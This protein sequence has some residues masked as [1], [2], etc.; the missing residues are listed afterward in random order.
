MQVLETNLKVNKETAGSTYMETAP[1]NQRGPEMFQRLLGQ[2]LLNKRLHIA[3]CCSLLLPLR[4]KVYD[5]FC[6]V[7]LVLCG[8]SSLWGY[9]IIFLE[10][11]HLNK[12]LSILP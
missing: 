2:L 1:Q 9:V 6:G 4:N 8:N 11:V 7:M 3:N 5:K 10:R 12:A